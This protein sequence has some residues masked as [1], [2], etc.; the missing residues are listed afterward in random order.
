MLRFIKS[1][2]VNVEVV[3]LTSSGVGILCGS[4]VTAKRNTKYSM[5]KQILVKEKPSYNSSCPK[6]V[7]GCLLKGDKGVVTSPSF[8]DIYPSDINCVWE[9]VAPPNF[10]VYLNFTHFD[11]ENPLDEDFCLY[12]SM[13]ILSKTFVNGKRKD[14][15]SYCGSQLPPMMKSEENLIR[16]EFTSDN[17]MQKSGFSAV[18]F[19]DVNE[20]AVGNG[21]CEQICTDTIGSYECW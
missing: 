17:S 19:T 2:R 20:C 1:G 14:K 10:H 5:K 7:C 12:D 11:L 4:N 18:F 3:G 15:A 16:I 21:G 9:I 6:D 8:P 13:N